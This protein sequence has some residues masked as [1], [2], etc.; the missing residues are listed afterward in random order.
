MI[1][2]ISFVVVDLSYQADQMGIY[3]DNL[4]FMMTVQGHS[5][6]ARMGLLLLGS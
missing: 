6:E 1:T 3:H 2:K 5:E 4:A